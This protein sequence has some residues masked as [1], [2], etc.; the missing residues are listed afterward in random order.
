MLTDLQTEKLLQGVPISNDW[1]W[2]S[3]SPNAVENNVKSILAEIKRKTRTKDKV[4]YGHYGSGYA[5]FIDA[6][7]YREDGGFRD[8]FPN[9]YNGLVILFSRLTDYFVLGEGNKSWHSTGGSSY[10]PSFEMVDS[11]GTPAVKEL[12]QRVSDIVSDRG[13]KRLSSDELEKRVSKDLVVPTILSD[14]PW[15]EFDVIFHWED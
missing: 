10:L 5:S 2:S 12:E 4:E 3:D 7:I 1:P 8:D 14:R 6:F 15:R 9:S 11:S 13:L